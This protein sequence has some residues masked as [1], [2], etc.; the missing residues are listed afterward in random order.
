MNNGSH[1]GVGGADVPQSNT[2]DKR[3]FLFPR[4]GKEQRLAENQISASL[5]RYSCNGKLFP[6]QTSV[7]AIANLRKLFC[8]GKQLLSLVREQLD[9]R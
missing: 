9:K 7:V 4:A 5:Y 6:S 8:Q 2:F 1:G 3:L